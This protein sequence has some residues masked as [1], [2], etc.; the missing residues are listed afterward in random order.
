LAAVVESDEETGSKNAETSSSV[1]VIGSLFGKAADSLVGKA[2]SL[3]GKAGSMVAKGR[4]VVAKGESAGTKSGSAV[5]KAGL[6]F[7]AEIC[8][9]F[10][11]L[12][13]IEEE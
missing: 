13:S 5:S 4:S 11:E 7:G 12:K 3:V 8:P 6:A 10:V 1:E 2:G 9:V